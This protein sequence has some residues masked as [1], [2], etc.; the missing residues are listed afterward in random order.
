MRFEFHMVVAITV[1]VI[2]SVTGE[3]DRQQSILEKYCSL[4]AS[5]QG[6]PLFRSHSCSI[7]MGFYK[8][9]RMNWADRPSNTINSNVVYICQ[10]QYLDLCQSH[11]LT[12]INTYSIQQITSCFWY[13][14]MKCLSHHASNTM[15]SNRQLHK[16]SINVT[17]K[18][19]EFQHK[20]NSIWKYPSQGS[21]NSR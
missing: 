8:M 16:R 9:L 7:C 13:V 18:T 6:V 11:F 20:N 19:W 14:E 4:V 1:T 17:T 3:S 2:S 10:Q 15:A 12:V 5:F 21:F